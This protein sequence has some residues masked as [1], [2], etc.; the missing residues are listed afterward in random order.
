MKK[1]L[2][3]AAVAAVALSMSG[4]HSHRHH[5]RHGYAEPHEVRPPHR[6]P[7]PPPVVVKPVRY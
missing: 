4:C 6:H 3:L 1:L 5:G 7:V 2:A